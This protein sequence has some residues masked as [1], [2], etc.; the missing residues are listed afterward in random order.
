MECVE[1]VVRFKTKN[2]SVI[3]IAKL[4]KEQGKSVRQVSHLVSDLSGFMDAC[5]CA[6]EVLSCST[7]D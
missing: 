3:P 4:F 6:F 1:K 2:C 5:L 7:H